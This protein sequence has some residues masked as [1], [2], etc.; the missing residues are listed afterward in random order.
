[1][2]VAN[3]IVIAFYNKDLLQNAFKPKERKK[4]IQIKIKVTF[5]LFNAK[6]SIKKGKVEYSKFDMF[7]FTDMISSYLYSKITCTREHWTGKVSADMW[8]PAFPV[9][10]IGCL[11]CEKI[12]CFQII[13]LFWQVLICSLQFPV[14]L[15]FPVCTHWN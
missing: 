3:Q 2:S 4:E 10:L 1:M 7:T 6:W 11:Y 9:F 8:L 15:V 13:D 14:R 5:F 12:L